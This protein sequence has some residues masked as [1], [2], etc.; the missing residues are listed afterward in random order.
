MSRIFDTVN[1]F[2]VG[3]GA[4]TQGEIKCEICGKV[5]NEGADDDEDES[6]DDYSSV[7]HT[8]F[9]GMEVCECCFVEIENEILHRMSSILDWYRN[10]VKLR[11]EK[12][13][14]DN[15]K[16]RGLK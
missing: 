13:K 11:E 14:S 3:S 1:L 12:I 4:S 10:I 5:Y 8:M 9:A 2:G 16:L 6:Y 7:S 15:E